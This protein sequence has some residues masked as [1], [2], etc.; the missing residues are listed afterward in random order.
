MGGIILELQKETL[1][2]DVNVDT[3]IRKAYLVARKLKLND[4][5]K[6]LKLEMYGYNDGDVVPDYRKVKGLIYAKK[7]N[8]YCVPAQL[9]SEEEERFSSI[10]I[11]HPIIDINKQSKEGIRYYYKSEINAKLNKKGNF[12][13]IFYT[14]IDK[15]KLYGIVNIVINKILEWSLE[16]E[17]NGIVGDDISFSYDEV[18][19][20]KNISI[21]NIIS[22]NNC[23][24]VDNVTI[25]QGTYNKDA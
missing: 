7:A 22:F 18:E 23:N 3:L 11:I 8:G 12:E 4:F 17:E 14:E 21:T 16:L 9:S 2:K 19:K 24:S 6:W 1:N 25:Q 10:E 20:A 5:E 15:D 13:A